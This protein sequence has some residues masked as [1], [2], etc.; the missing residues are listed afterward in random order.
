MRTLSNPYSGCDLDSCG[1]YR[2]NLH[3]HSTISDGSADLPEVVERYYSL[4]YDILCMTDHGVVGKGWTAPP[5]PIPPFNL[6]QK[7]HPVSVR[8]AGEIARGVGRGGRGMV[9]MPLGIEHNIAVFRKNH[10]NGYFCDAGRGDFGK[11]NDHLTAV[12][13][14]DAAGGLSVLN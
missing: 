11:E 3:T 4:G 1:F 13:K 14:I 2:A 12:K 10:V 9:D 8:R 6:L 5:R 7:S